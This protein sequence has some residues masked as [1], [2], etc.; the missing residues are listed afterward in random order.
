FA[1]LK[2]DL[3]S[4]VKLQALRLEESLSKS[5]YWTTEAWNRL[6]VENVL[7]QKFAIGLI[8]GVYEDGS[9]AATFRYMDDGTFNTVDE[10]E[11]ELPEQAQIGLVH[12]LELDEETLA[13]WRTQL[14]DYEISQPFDQ[15]NRELFLPTEEELKADEVLRLP[16]GAYTPT[17]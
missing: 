15:L 4:M 6:F 1:Q 3:K 11:Y 8:W 17:A 5:R 2:K 13:G 10:D 16:D 7:M 14:E 12:P 9:L